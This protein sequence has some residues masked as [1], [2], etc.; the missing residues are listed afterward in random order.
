VY[1]EQIGIANEVP[2]FFGIDKFSMGRVLWR[3]HRE[4]LPEPPWPLAASSGTVGGDV[5]ALAPEVQEMQ[6]RGGKDAGAA[7]N[8]EA[9]TEAAEAPARNDDGVAEHT[10]M[11]TLWV[12]D[13]AHDTPDR[14]RH[15]LALHIHTASGMTG[16]LYRPAGQ[17]VVPFLVAPPLPPLSHFHHSTVCLR[18]P[19]IGN[20][21]FWTFPF[22]LQWG[23][24][25]LIGSGLIDNGRL[26]NVRFRSAVKCWDQETALSTVFS[27]RSFMR[28]RR[29]QPWASRHRPQLPGVQMLLQ[30]SL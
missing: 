19:Q 20:G 24:S 12:R 1:L 5:A 6:A 14:A 29:G 27:I 9:A 17:R 18:A 15:I 21:L 13:W 4:A 7:E 11:F 23:A 2:Q 25:R 30:A 3:R 8:G 16:L 22:L 10:A 26:D 28:E